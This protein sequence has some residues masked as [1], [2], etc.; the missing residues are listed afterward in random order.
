MTDT[1][2]IDFRGRL[3]QAIKR[4]MS[5]TV[6]GERAQ[7]TVPAVYPSGAGSC[8]DIVL[9][10]DKCFVTDMALGQTEA[11]LFGA[12][13]F[14]DNA[15]KTASARYGVGYDGLSVFAFWASIDNVESAISLVATTS[16]AAATSAIMKA[17]EEKERR[18][19]TELYKRVSSIF[20]E[21]R[22]TKIMDLTGRDATWTAHNVVRTNDDGHLAVFEFVSDS[23]IS[24]SSKFLMFSDLSKKKGKFSL[25]SVVSDISKVKGKTAMLADVSHILESSAPESD[26]VRYAEAA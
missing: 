18:L 11:E 15:A 4:L 5:V 24:V 10:G 3:D 16:V 1:R 26:F 8:V 23:T 6:K 14:Y 20:G 25:N 13:D 2:A 7:V 19:H 22:V 17:S 21:K 9:N 12:S